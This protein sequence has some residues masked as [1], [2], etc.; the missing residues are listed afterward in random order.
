MKIIL[1]LI[2]QPFLTAVSIA[3]ISHSTWSFAVMF[4]GLEPYPQFTWSWW[5][6]VLPSAIMA[7]SIDIGLLSLAYQI[8]AGQ[9]NPSKLAAFAVLS[10]AMFYAQFVYISSHMPALALAAGVRAEW[11]EVVQLVR[12]CSIWILPALLPVALILY[13]FSDKDPAHTEAVATA[14]TVDDTRAPLIVNIEDDMQQPVPTLPSSETPALPSPETVNSG[15]PE[16]SAEIEQLQPTDSEV[17]STVPALPP[18]NEQSI[19]LKRL[20]TSDRHCAHC[21]SPLPTDARANRLYCDDTCKQLAHVARKA[22][23]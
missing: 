21:G 2:R 3:A 10:G 15:E 6:W 14:P 23:S 11:A 17:P 12:D 7:F 19:S 16:P 18:A 22:N 13:A 5:A 20:R 4:T 8:R 1:H 9:R